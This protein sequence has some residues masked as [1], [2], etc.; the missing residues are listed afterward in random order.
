MLNPEPS[1]ELPLAH[2][3]SHV[4][5]ERAKLTNREV[6]VPESDLL[7]ACAH[8]QFVTELDS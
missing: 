6:G 2:R 1:I 7:W 8:P 5:E 4:R 3:D